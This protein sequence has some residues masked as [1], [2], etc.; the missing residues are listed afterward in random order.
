MFLFVLLYACVTMGG[1]STARQLPVT[2]LGTAFYVTY[3]VGG[4][5]AGSGP[6]GTG[7]SGGYGGLM[8]TAPVLAPASVARESCC[9]R[10]RDVPGVLV[11]RRGHQDLVTSADQALPDT[12]GV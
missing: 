8:T 3:A 10:R 5:P 9:F 7:Y 1:M 6:Y 2:G 4:V 12:T 11:M